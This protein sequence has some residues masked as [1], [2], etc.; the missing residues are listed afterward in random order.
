MVWPPSL[1]TELPMELGILALVA[2]FE[3]GDICLMAVGGGAL[4]EPPKSSTRRW[5]IS[6]EK[7]KSLHKS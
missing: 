2:V 4:A 5:R 7:N 6:S 3:D 1:R